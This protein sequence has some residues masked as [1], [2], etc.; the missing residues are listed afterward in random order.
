MYVL[1][2]HE[3]PGLSLCMNPG[4]DQRWK[5]RRA[6]G[7]ASSAR[8][9]VRRLPRIQ[10]WS[11]SRQSYRGAERSWAGEKGRGVK[12]RPLTRES[13]ILTYVTRCKLELNASFKRKKTLEQQRVQAELDCERRCDDLKTELHLSKQLI[14]ELTQAR[15]QV[16]SSCVRHLCQ[17]AGAM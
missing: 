12:M 5:R 16:R 17:T 10:R 11:N 1:S 2:V 13:L 9:P 6:A 8:P 15:D 3:A 7:I 14:E 4:F